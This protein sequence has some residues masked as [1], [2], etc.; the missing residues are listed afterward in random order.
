MKNDATS[1]MAAGI[2]SPGDVKA[3]LFDLCRGTHPGRV[4]ADEITMFKSVGTAIED[5]A[6]EVVEI[7]KGGVASHAATVAANEIEATS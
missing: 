3:D 2:I 4:S 1:M 5:L 7:Y 6:A